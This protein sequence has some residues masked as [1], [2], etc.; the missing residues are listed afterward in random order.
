MDPTSQLPLQHLEVA[1]G[2]LAAKIWVSLSCLWV[3]PLPIS[4]GPRRCQVSLCLAKVLPDLVLVLSPELQVSGDI[5]G[6]PK[7]LA[8]PPE[9]VGLGIARKERVRLTPER[10]EGALE[11]C[12]TEAGHQRSCRLLFFYPQPG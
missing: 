10:T 9:L 1:V 8:A 4:L 7:S 2:V 11:S 3:F 12:R 5:Q 6:D